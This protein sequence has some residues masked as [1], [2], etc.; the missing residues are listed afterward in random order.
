ML[1]YMY[2]HMCTCLCAHVFVSVLVYLLAEAEQFFTL[3]LPRLSA[4]FPLSN[5][6]YENISNTY[7]VSFTMWSSD[8]KS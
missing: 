4:L 2:V 6:S 7:W 5:I 8:Y 3:H 1:W